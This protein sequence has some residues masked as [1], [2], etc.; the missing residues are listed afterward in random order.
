MSFHKITNQSIDRR[1]LLSSSVKV[2]YSGL[3]TSFLGGGVSHGS[4]SQSKLNDVKD[5]NKE[6]HFF[7]MINIPDGLD[8]SYLFDARPLAMT[9]KSLQVNYLSEAPVPFVGTNGGSTLR[10]SLTEPLMKWSS[11]FSVINGVV[12]S[13]SFDGHDQNMNIL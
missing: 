6:P 13:P 7:L 5:A 1:S 12:M 3:F 9:E 11:R 10:T 4:T 2:T 8:T